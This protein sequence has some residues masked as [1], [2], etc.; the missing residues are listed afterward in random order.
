MIEGTLVITS[1]HP[2][3]SVRTTKIDMYP[4]RREWDEVCSF[5]RWEVGVPR[6]SQSSGP[7]ELL[8]SDADG[9]VASRERLKTSSRI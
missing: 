6:M 4:A 2:Q 9:C 3:L 7:N 5:G 8:A 1:G